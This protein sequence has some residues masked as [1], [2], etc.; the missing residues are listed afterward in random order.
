MDTAISFEDRLQSWREEWERK[1]RKRW[2]LWPVLL[3]LD[4]CY[5]QICE[6]INH[7]LGDY[8][9]PMVIS[10]A[11][12]I[13]SNPAT[14][15]VILGVSIIVFL[16]FHAYM[17]TRTPRKP[18]QPKKPTDHDQSIE[19]SLK[20]VPV[21]QLINQLSSLSGTHGGQYLSPQIITGMLSELERLRRLERTV[22]AKESSEIERQEAIRAA[23]NLIV[24]HATGPDGYEHITFQNISRNAARDISIDCLSVTDSRHCDSIPENL[25]IV[26]DD[27][28]A[29]V[30]KLKTIR[31]TFAEFMSI[32]G[33]HY[34]T[35]DFEDDTHAHNF[36]R[37]Y[38]LKLHDDNSI[39]WIPLSITLR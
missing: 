1:L 18:I 8:G 2:W 21:W 36:R 6:S 14:V 12:Y 24:S 38:E 15:T 19:A 4:L 26:R 31:G 30:V 29:K 37:E 11:S 7:L 13:P 3:A 16:G 25:P 39:E 34:A 22:Q 5:H 27:S 17:E 23:P 28:N 33:K 32:G 9:G 35:V 20:T 10:L